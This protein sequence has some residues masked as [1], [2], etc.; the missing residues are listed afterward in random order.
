MGQQPEVAE[1]TLASR[2]QLLELPHRVERE[3][4]HHKCRRQSSRRR[5]VVHQPRQ[6]R[7]D[8]R[9]QRVH[10]LQQPHRCHSDLLAPPRRPTLVVFLRQC[11][12]QVRHSAGGL[13]NQIHFL[14]SADQLLTRQRVYLDLPHRLRLAVQAGCSRLRLGVETFSPAP[15]Q[16]VLEALV[17]RQAALGHHLLE[18]SLA[19]HQ[20][21]SLQTFSVGVALVPQQKFPGEAGEA[22][23]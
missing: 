18:A 17:R 10:L 23:R 8:F 19:L 7:L 4:V 5:G 2:P 9:G 16:V 12:V 14:G 13:K 15:H 22:R 3:V 6:Q 20:A 11:P 21:V 1:Q